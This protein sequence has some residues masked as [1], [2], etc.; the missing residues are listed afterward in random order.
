[1]SFNRILIII[2]IILAGAGFV[3]SMVSFL[4][5]SNGNLKSSVAV[6]STVEKNEE[7][8][9]RTVKA[10]LPDKCQAPAG[11]SQQGWREHMSHHP[12]RYKEC[13]EAAKQESVVGYHNITASD[14]DDMLEHKDFTLLDV[15]I[16]EQNHIAGT[17][18]LIPFN[19]IIQRQAELPQ[20]KNA[21]IVLYCRSGSMSKRAAEDLNKLGYTNVYNLEGGFI[22]WQKQG[23]EVKSKSL[24]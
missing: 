12:D 1:M 14:L 18:A 22:E 17:D 21:K 5:N 11:Y 2:L 6:I 7:N 15:H 9:K 13:F 19:E 20:D 23:Y 10:E 16:P 4:N 24:E 8:F 3:W